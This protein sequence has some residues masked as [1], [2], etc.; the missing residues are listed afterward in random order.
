MGDPPA[1]G[2]W[3]ARA[4]ELAEAHQAVLGIT[5]RLQKCW[6]MVSRQWEPQAICQ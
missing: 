1:G 2:S 6:V 4:F 3:L 5:R